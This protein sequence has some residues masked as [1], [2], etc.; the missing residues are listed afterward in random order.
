MAL[1]LRGNQTEASIRQAQSNIFKPITLN[2]STSTLSP[3]AAQPSIIGQTYNQMVGQPDSNFSKYAGMLPS[4]NQFTELPGENGFYSSMS[5]LE[6][7]SMRLANAA[8]QRSIAEAGYGSGLKM[9]ENEAEYGLKGMLLGKE[10]GLRGDLAQR[11][12]NIQTQSVAQ[13]AGYSSPLEMQADI[14]RQRR[15]REAKEKEQ[16]RITKLAFR[17]YD[18][19]G[20]PY[21]KKKV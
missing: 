1:K 21:G 5:G 19:Y 4:T 10:Y 20:R 3:P 12:S 11:E 6:G 9:R 18:P 2:S 8:S 13:R 17:G 14:A 7:A 15:E 16:E